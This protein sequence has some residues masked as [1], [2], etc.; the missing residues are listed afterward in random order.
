ML[1]WT[2]WGC[3]SKIGLKSLF[4]HEDFT[5]F[6]LWEASNGLPVYVCQ[7]I[8]RRLIGELIVQPG[9]RRPSVRRRLFQ[10][11]SLRKP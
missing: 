10:T 5:F 7:R 3:T 9:I 8:S 11:I 1:I 2:S 4:E 6:E